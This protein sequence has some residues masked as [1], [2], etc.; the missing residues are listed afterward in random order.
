MDISKFFE[1]QKLNTKDIVIDS[2][3]TDYKIWARKYLQLH[4]K[5][6]SLADKTQC[7]KYWVSSNDEAEDMQGI[8][9]SYL[10][11]LSQILNVGI[12]K[13]YDT[14]TE[15]TVNPNEY[16][17]SDQFLN[18]FI[19]LNDLI[20]APSLDHYITLFEDFISLGLTLGY[21]EEQITESFLL[22]ASN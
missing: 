9:D 10:T 19:D 12:G 4:T 13:N 17:L 14:I 20:I 16:C 8:F 2:S 7:Y 1:K 21:S 22:K 11:A 3:L 6:S 15:I 5:L 18:L